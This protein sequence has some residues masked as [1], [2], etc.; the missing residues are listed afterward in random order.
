MIDCLNETSLSQDF[1]LLFRKKCSFPDGC[2]HFLYNL[3]EMLMVFFFFE[4]KRELVTLSL[5]VSFLLCRMS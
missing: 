5:H 2:K 3:F 4:G 1:H